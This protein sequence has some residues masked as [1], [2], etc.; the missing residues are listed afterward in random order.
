VPV[1]IDIQR[2]GE[3]DYVVRLESEGEVVDSWVH[4][5]PEALA[6]L[7]VPAEREEAV[8]T[9]TIEFLLHHQGVPDF[10]R[11]VELEDVVAGYDNFATA[12]G[13]GDL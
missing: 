2:D 1:S 8:V 10:P 9:R 5:A 13:A 11:I 4:V 6:D 3:H 12:I 7:G